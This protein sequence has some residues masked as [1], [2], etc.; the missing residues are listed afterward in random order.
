[1]TASPPDTNLIGGL[2]LV[3]AG[4]LLCQWTR[5]L[6][7]YDALHFPGRL[8]NNVDR[9]NLIVRSQDNLAAASSYRGVESL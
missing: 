4:G 1:M 2:Q 3:G 8:Y 5:Y 6:V 7:H 9:K